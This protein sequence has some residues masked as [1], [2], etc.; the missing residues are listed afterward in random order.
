MS[1][2]HAGVLSHGV[3][4]SAGRGGGAGGE[5][6]GTIEGGVGADERRVMQMHRSSFHLYQDF[7]Y[8]GSS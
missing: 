4:W 1:T 3:E 7:G 6:E 5:A 2:G 8:P